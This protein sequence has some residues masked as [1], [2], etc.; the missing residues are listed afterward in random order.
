MPPGVH[1]FRLWPVSL[2]PLRPICRSTLLLLCYSTTTIS[3]FFNYFHYPTSSATF[4]VILI[5]LAFP[6]RSLAFTLCTEWFQAKIGP[7]VRCLHRHLCSPST[8]EGYRS[9]STDNWAPDLPLKGVPS[10]RNGGVEDIQ[11]SM[12]TGPLEKEHP[13]CQGSLTQR[14]FAAPFDWKCSPPK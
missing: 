1:S 7:F 2:I 11:Q 13:F 8:G 6:N 9:Y 10:K 14:G 12:F 5:S 4:E 3:S